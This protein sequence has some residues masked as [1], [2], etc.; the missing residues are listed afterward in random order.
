MK[1]S[2]C[3]SHP[4]GSSKAEDTAFEG[5]CVVDTVLLFACALSDLG[6]ASL[7]GSMWRSSLA[8]LA[9]SWPLRRGTMV[10]VFGPFGVVSVVRP[11]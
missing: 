5:D 10:D 3:R 8:M 11:K 7:S 6:M 9:S 2:S 1:R 4:L